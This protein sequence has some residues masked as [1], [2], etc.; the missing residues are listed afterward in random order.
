VP[1]VIAIRDY[2][3]PVEILDAQRT[4]IAGRAEGFVFTT[5]NGTPWNDDLLV[6]R[7]L[8]KAA[9]EW[10]SAHVQ[11]FVCDSPASRGSAR[12][13]REQAAWTRKHFHDAQHPRPRSSRTFATV[14]AYKSENFGTKR[15]LEPVGVA[16]EAQVA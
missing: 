15:A 9:R 5:V 14:R 3:L 12:S 7:H 13:R 4:H 8:Q 16:E 2:P 10:I 1:T 6:K 11:A